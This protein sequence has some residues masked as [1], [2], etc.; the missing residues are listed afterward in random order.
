M[1][2]AWWATVC[3]VSKSQTR[4]RRL[5]TCLTGESHLCTDFGASPLSGPISW[6]VSPS[7]AR[8]GGALAWPGE[9]VL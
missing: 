1:D 6:T 9:V 8:R 4:L 5:S 2:R 3:M 7:V